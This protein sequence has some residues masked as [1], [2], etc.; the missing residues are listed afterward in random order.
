MKKSRSVGG[1][2]SVLLPVA[3]CVLFAVIGVFLF[4]GHTQLALFVAGLGMIG[5]LLKMDPS[6]LKRLP[7]LL[8]LGYVVFSGLTG[9]WALSGKFFLNE[10]GK[11]FIAAGLFLFVI[12]KKDPSQT[13]F[14]NLMILVAGTSAVLAALSV[15]AATSGVTQKL[16]S[17][18]PELAAVGMGF[19]AGTR[20]T[21]VLGNPNIM[22]SILALGIFFSIALLCGSNTRKEQTLFAAFLSLNAFA[23]LLSFSMGGIA[24]FVVSILV[25]LLFSGAQRGPVLTRMLEG[26]LPAL[27]WGFASFPFFNRGTPLVFLPLVF[28]VCNALSVI[29]L[30]QKVAPRMAARLEQR[31]T[32]VLVLL[33]GILALGVTYGI[34]GYHLTGP[35]TFQG[36]GLRRSAYPEAGTYTLSVDATDD[37]QVTITSQTMP[38]VMMHTDTQ[39]YQGSAH[40]AQFTVPENSEVCYFT[41]SAPEGVVL[42][43]VRLSSGEA[44]RL[45]YTLLPGFIANRLQ[46]LWANQNA[47]QRTVFFQDGLKLF[48]RQPLLGNGVGSVET[49][50]TSVQDF[51]YESRYVHN[52][53]IQL[54]AETGLPGFLLYVGALLSL[55]VL[56]FKNRTILDGDRLVWA[57]PALW[58]ALT[59][60]ATHAMV[61]VSMSTIIFLCYAFLTF[62]MIV[63]ACPA[64]APAAPAVEAEPPSK[65]KKQAPQKKSRL[66]LPNLVLAAL[67]ALFLL[68]VCMNVAAEHIATSRASSP[69]H[70]LSNLARAAAMDPYE[71]NDYKMT[72]VIR[73]LDDLTPDHKA[74]A[75]QYAAELMQ[76][77]SNS[78]PLSM[79]HYYLATGQYQ[80]AIQAAKAAATYSSSNAAVWN[81][82]IQQLRYSL[83]DSEPSPL[84]GPEGE[85]LLSSLLDYYGML[86]E[87]NQTSMEAIQLDEENEAFFRMVLELAQS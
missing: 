5:A 26:A 53:Y 85:A 84:Q 23:F 33:I 79:C 81:A 83:L 37:V 25:Y 65:R 82:V 57:Y 22:A 21:G 64:E 7:I 18:I 10:F 12:Y 28:L 41:F 40:Q 70:T 50:V 58:A 80:P 51:Y 2:G 45:N 38:Q 47:I 61:E 34:A 78:L 30:E 46:G 32:L 4:A 86:Q 15:E 16:F 56:L 31:Q 48:L 14:R 17:S 60:I 29:L 74:Q 68:T 6:R 63:C 55:A 39:L 66:K 75:D 9:F 19:E 24:C 87:H 3:A 36:E 77:H 73:A 71:A 1:Q 72:Y 35:F 13:K 27:L 52:H 11:I 44:L 43:E 76:A 67:P 69:A 62:G 49:G 42:S 59:M 20:L 54:L 8:L